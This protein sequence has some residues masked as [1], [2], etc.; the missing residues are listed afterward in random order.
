[1][2]DRPVIIPFGIVTQDCLSQDIEGE[3]SSEGDKVK[4]EEN[5]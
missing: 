3:G 2:G 1:M 5:K 4:K